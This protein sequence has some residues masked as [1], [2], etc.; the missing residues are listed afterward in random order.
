[1]RLVFMGTPE[2]AIP[3]LKRCIDDSHEV[4]SVWTQ[5]DK[6]RGRHNIV[7]APPVKQFALANKLSVEQP[8][9]LKTEEVSRLFAACR[10]DVAVVVAYGKILPSSFLSAPKH[11]CINVHLSL[12][13]KYR[14]AAP[15]SWAI[16]NG[17][18]ETGVTTMLM[19]EGL[20]T[21]DILL[22]RGVKI[23][24]DETAPELTE[25]LAWLGAELLG[26]TLQKL[27]EIR[28]TPQRE[29]DASRAPIL[30]KEDGKIDWT[31]SAVEIERRV[32]GLQPWPGAYSFLHGRKLSIW[33]AKPSD[34]DEK[35]GIPGEIIAAR[36][37][38]VIACGFDSA[39]SLVDVQLEGRRRMRAEEFLLGARIEPGERLG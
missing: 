18:T 10:S 7:S 9:S 28:R 27:E 25:R 22:Q 34:V 13:P 8:A 5:P 14:G 33:Q 11:G 29:E 4:V 19:D 23:Y 39:L 3:T 6:P 2:S 32:R 12:L 30:K 35:H 17:E 21:G 1:M 31:L 38:L 24:P 37:E 36:E 26:E 20:D 16:I 15:V